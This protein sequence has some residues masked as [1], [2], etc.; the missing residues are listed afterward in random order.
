[1]KYEM[2]FL[3]TLCGIGILTKKLTWKQ[4]VAVGVFVWIFIMYNWKR[5]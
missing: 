4:W 3:F 5:G 2:Y 1:M